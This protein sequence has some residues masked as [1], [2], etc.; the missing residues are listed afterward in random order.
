MDI[1]EIATM[2]GTFAGIVTPLGGVGA[3]LYRKQAKRLKEAEAQL[4]E[5]NVSKAKIEGKAEEFHIWK[6]QCEALSELNNKLTE[7]NQ[8][9]VQMN[10]EKEDRHQEDIKDRED[11]FKEQTNLL[12]DRQKELVAA[13][14]REREHVRLESQLERERDHYKLWMCCREHSSLDPIEGCD[15]RKPTQFRPIKYIPMV[16]NISIPPEHDK[17]EITINI[18][19]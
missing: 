6:E 5:A 18:E 14:E 15:R 9:L 4:A 3:W 1:T 11:R 19:N 8:Q 13:L 17:E 2:L 10:A 7:R 12:R 16:E